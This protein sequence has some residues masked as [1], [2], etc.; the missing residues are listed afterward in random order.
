MATHE[1]GTGPC[2]SVEVEGAG[3]VP[4]VSM[5]ERMRDLAAIDPISIAFANG[6][7]SR[8]KSGA[9]LSELGYANIVG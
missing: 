7:V 5:F 1:R 4:R 8:V 9:R 6:R 3:H 2:H